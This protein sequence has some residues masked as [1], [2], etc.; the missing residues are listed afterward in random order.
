VDENFES[1]LYGQSQPEWLERSDDYN[2]WEEAR[3]AEDMDAG[4]GR[5]DVTVEDVLEGIVYD[6]MWMSFNDDYQRELAVEA[7]VKALV[8]AGVVVPER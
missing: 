7:V 1:E 6:A 4:E 2:V 5:P 8:A 3:I